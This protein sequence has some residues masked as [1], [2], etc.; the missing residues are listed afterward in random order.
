MNI[1]GIFLHNKIRTGGDRRYLELMEGLAAGG[2]KVLVI[3]NSFLDYTPLHLQSIYIPVSYTYRGFPPAS[4]LFRHAIKNN[5]SFIRSAIGTDAMDFLHIHGDTQLKVAL[6]LKKRLTLP[7]F[8]ASRC[9]DIDRAHI[10][11]KSGGLSPGEY[12][13]SI[14]YEPVNRHREKLIAKYADL[15]TFQNDNDRQCFYK[16]T[17]APSSKTLI[18]PG[19]IGPPRCTP[20]YQN[21]NKSSG[22]RNILYVGVISS[23]KGLWD[24]LKALAVLKRHGTKEFTCF[25]L[26]RGSELA[27]AENLVRELAIEDHVYFEGFKDPFPYYVSC[28][29]M[30]YPTLYDAFPDTILEALHTGCPVIASA[31]GGVP[32]ILHYSE[33]LFESGNIGE[34]AAIIEKSIHDKEHYAHLRTLCAERAGV[35]HFDWP[36]CF[37]DAM[38]DFLEG[39]HPDE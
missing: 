34:I 23:T 39:R 12:L 14:F 24:L 31:V 36:R 27:K 4:W 9:N 1:L 10:V 7:L 19:N 21:K 26:G 15:I 33:L 28:D 6:F 22:V 25:V 17:S 20:E 38:K 3:M 30:V 13:F 35:Y 5:L 11:R 16:R 2:N 8:Y 18:I 32:D 29:L 37:E